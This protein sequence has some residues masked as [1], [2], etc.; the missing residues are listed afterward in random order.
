MKDHKLKTWPSMFWPVVH[1]EK[2]IEYRKNDRDFQVDDTL[3][4][5]EWEPDTGFYTGAY[6]RVLVKE[7]WKGIPGLPADYCI[8]EIVVSK[9]PG[10]EPSTEDERS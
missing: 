8:M 10:K 1:E 7:V 2:K 6:V 3:C 9:A 5:Q 4:L